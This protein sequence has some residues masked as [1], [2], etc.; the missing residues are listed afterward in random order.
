MWQQICENLEDYRSCTVLSSIDFAKAFNRV[1]FQHCLRA[2]AK[3]G[4][5]TE[6]IALIATFLSDRTMTLKIGETWSDKR[7]VTGG[8]PQG[9]V[10]GVFLFNVSTDNLEDDFVQYEQVRLGLGTE[11]GQG[12]AMVQAGEAVGEGVRAEGAPYTSTPTNRRQPV[13][14]EFD[15]SPIFSYSDLSIV[16]SN[17]ARNIPIEY[18]R[19]GLITPPKEKKVG[20]QVLEEKA[21]LIF[22]YVDDIL[23]CEKLNMGQVPITIEGG[24]NLKLKQALSSQN[25]FRIITKNARRK[26]MKVNNSKTNVLC[27]SDALNYSPKTFFFD[28]DG[29]KI[30]SV[31]TMKLLGFYFSERPTVE[32]HLT[33][34]KKKF[35]Q[36]FWTLRHLKKVGFNEPELVKVYKSMLLPIADYCDVVYHSMLTDEGDQM[37]ERLQV[38]ALKCI[39]DATLSGRKLQEKAGLETLRE[40]RIKSCDKFA[41]KCLASERFSKFF[42]LK[43][44]R[45]SARNHEKYVESYSRCERL[46]NS[47]VFYMRR[48]LNGKPGKV[49]GK[50]NREYRV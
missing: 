48:R 25:A 22:K 21:V 11:Q 28:S 17:R 1:S 42:P 9:S 30:E 41:N 36:R 50:R 32:A 20:T 26:G 39:F 12:P 33:S 3:K 13:D 34:I 24:K 2:F 31:S 29:E 35:R 15:A 7:S 14:P 38:T 46:K 5:S 47:P 23:I 43:Q 19:E 6:V 45:Q 49:Y 40:R 16:F 10:L 27:I 8:C 44:G 4:A 18:S 37:L